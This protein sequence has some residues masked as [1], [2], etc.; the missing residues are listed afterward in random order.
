MEVS[1]FS[2][3]ELAS[4][5]QVLVDSTES[6]AEMQHGYY[7]NNLW[8]VFA[9]VTTHCPICVQ[10]TIHS[11]FVITSL[12]PAF[13]RIYP[14]LREDL[15]AETF[16]HTHNSGVLLKGITDD[17]FI[18][19]FGRNV[20]G[21]QEESFLD[22][23]KKV[24]ETSTTTSD[25]VTPTSYPTGKFEDIDVSTYTINVDN[26][27]ISTNISKKQED[28]IKELVIIPTAAI[29]ENITEFT[30]E[31]Q[32]ITN[33]SDRDRIII[34]SKTVTENALNNETQVEASE[35]KAKQ[36]PPKK[37]VSVKQPQKLRVLKLKSVKTTKARVT[38]S[39]TTTA[40]TEN[41]SP[42]ST[43]FEVSTTESILDES[44]ESQ[45]ELALPPKHVNT[46]KEEVPLKLVHDP[47]TTEKAKTIFAPE[48]KND[49]YL[50][51]DKEEL[52][53]MLREVVN[54]EVKKKS[55]D[56]Y[57]KELKNTT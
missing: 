57:L 46:E 55:L 43:T 27:S 4:T 47:H 16:F 15:A 3:F 39:T 7:A 48:I 56:G 20:S 34:Q 51:L 29:G 13:V 33:T 12:R 42:D 19:W 36:K 45:T 32:N 54:S 2:G 49:R 40:P 24:L 21:P 44:T 52:W 38:T 41:Y 37:A 11:S 30:T 10:Y 22:S 26:D 9:N 1:L 17:D 50:L 31:I 6:M 28:S 5:T 8:F 14:T 53:G 23:C 25:N 35:I 18:A